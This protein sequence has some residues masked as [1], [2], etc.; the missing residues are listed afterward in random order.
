MHRDRIRDRS[1]ALLIACGAIGS[2]PSLA[3]ARC[4]EHAL[5]CHEES[6]AFHWREGPF[7]SVMLDTGWVPADAPLQVRFAVFLG[8][9]TVI[10]LAGTSFT[11]WPSP[12]TQAVPGT[13]GSGSISIDY[14]LELLARIRIDVEVGGAR[15]RWEGDVPGLPIPRDLRAAAMAR[16]DSMLLAPQMP[17]PVA[18]ADATERVPV[19]DAD[20][21]GLAGIPGLRGGFRVEA[22][23]AL[24][25]AYQTERIEIGDAPRPITEEG[26][27]TV[28]GP[29]EGQTAFGAAKDVVI[30]PVGS[31]RYDG[32]V[33]VY[34]LFY[35]E[36]AGSRFD[37]PIASIPIPIADVDRDVA[38]E[39][40][41][42]H[43]PLPD[44]RVEPRE[45][46]FGLVELG[47][48][49]GGGTSVARR[50][51]LLRNEG[52]FALEVAPRRP[53]PPFE[54]DV[55]PITLPPR[56]ERRVEVRFAPTEPGRAAAMLWLDTNDPDES[57]IVVR[58]AGTA[59]AR[60]GGD[61]GGAS[62]DGGTRPDAAV[63]TGA[64][65]AGGCGCRASGTG[66]P[67]G[68]LALLGLVVARLV[69][70]RAGF[71]LSGALR[72]RRG[73]GRARAG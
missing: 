1:R 6:V 72:P 9:Q 56:S 63:G 52:E 24:G 25:A 23:A 73:S 37:Y 13:P 29:D 59:E 27:S 68:A 14:G 21:A 47:A 57:L 45:V 30:R 22:E 39:P 71:R 32:T 7:D 8:G 58:L 2:V 46:D 53:L 28:L 61:A 19:F 4:P 3:E 62:S 67:C 41:I 50:L 35:V 20:L 55:A 48:D 11:W 60:A 12:L 34:P 42:V 17:R 38:F 33:T 70:R 15:Y 69:H 18:V 43:V 64:T 65:T 5:G 36:V 66:S 40:A 51:L 49:P 54:V 10:D 26:G 16:F 44:A 31:L